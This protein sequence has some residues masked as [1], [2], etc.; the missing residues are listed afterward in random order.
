MLMNLLSTLVQFPHKIEHKVS[1]LWCEVK[2]HQ[3]VTSTLVGLCRNNPL[4]WVFQAP[5]ILYLG[6]LHGLNELPSLKW[7]TGSNLWSHFCT[8]L[9]VSPEFF[10]L[11]E[12]FSWIPSTWKH[13]KINLKS[14]L[15]YFMPLYVAC[16]HE[17]G[18]SDKIVPCEGAPRLRYVSYFFY[19]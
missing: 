17:P 15:T 7:R 5:L 18:H 2:V 12:L 11:K 9:W 19:M 6:S 13:H 14:I 16:E 8:C 10:C 3:L 4:P 1:S